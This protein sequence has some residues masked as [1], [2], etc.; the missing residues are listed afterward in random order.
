[1][2]AHVFLKIQFQSFRHS[3]YYLH[4]P[5]FPTSLR[6]RT[7]LQIN[8]TPNGKAVLQQLIQDRSRPTPRGSSRFPTNSTY[9]IGAGLNP[10]SSNEERKNAEWKRIAV[11]SCGNWYYTSVSIHHYQNTKA[12]PETIPF[13]A[14]V[15]VCVCFLSYSIYYQSFEIKVMK[16]VSKYND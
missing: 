10:L 4:C 2:F 13:L 1:M 14:V 7:Q 11:A 6:R 16:Y 12:W 15:C 3:S 9:G 8:L 5:I